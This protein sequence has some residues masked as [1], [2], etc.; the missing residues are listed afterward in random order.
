VTRAGVTVPCCL[1]TSPSAI[2]HAT[3]IGRV[4]NDVV[5]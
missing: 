5:N 2:V 4:T 3:A 1:A